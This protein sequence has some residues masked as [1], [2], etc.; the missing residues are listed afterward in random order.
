MGRFDWQAINHPFTELLDG[1]Q[2]AASQIDS[3]T[4]D[5]QWRRDLLKTSVFEQLRHFRKPVLL[6][7]QSAASVLS[8]QNSRVTSEGRNNQW[9]VIVTK[10]PPGISR[11]WMCSR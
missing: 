2:S 3:A 8:G 5:S 1:A 6:E 9:G 7:V 11:L 4:A 10:A